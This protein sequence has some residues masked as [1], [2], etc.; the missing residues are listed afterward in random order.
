M[1]I[2]EL[3]DK[4]WRTTIA[5]FTASRR[6]HRSHVASTLSVAFLSATVIG[7]NVLVF[8]PSFENEGKLI[9]VATIILSL[10]ALVMS[11][12]VALMRYEAKETN[13]HECGMELRALNKRIDIF[14]EDNFDTEGNLKEGK[15]ISKEINEEFQCAYDNILRKYNL[16]HTEFDYQYAQLGYLQDFPKSGSEIMKLKFRWHIWNVYLL[17]YLIAFVPF[18]LMLVLLLSGTQGGCD[19]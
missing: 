6:M 19:C 8:L 5:R 17:Y 10:F 4:I 18:I 2:N 16:N 9:T 3:S 14:I 1:F 12:L 7:I 15:T 11:L 13:Y